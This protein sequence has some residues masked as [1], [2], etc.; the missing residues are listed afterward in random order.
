MTNYSNYPVFSVTDFSNSI[1]KIV[2]EN[3]QFVRIRGEISRPAFPASGHIYFSLKDENGSISAIIWKYNSFNLNLTLEEGLEVICSGKITTFSTQSKYQILVENI[4]LAG[5]GALLKLLELRKK[6]LA[7]EGI[8]DSKYKKKIPFLPKI[9]GVVTSLSGAVIKDI[10]NRLEDRFPSHVFIWPVSVQGKNASFEIS[11]A[12]KGFNSKTFFK[13]L[14]KP[15][16]IIVARGGGSIEDLWCFNEELIIRAVFESEIPVISAIGHETDTTLIDLVADLRV[17]TPSAAA[18]KAVPVLNDLKYKLRDL[19]FRL[20]KNIS[21]KISQFDN[22]LEAS[23]LLYNQL[24]RLI[25]MKRQR[26]DLLL[27]DYNYT[28]ANLISYKSNQISALAKKMNSPEK[29]LLIIENTFHLL[30]KQIKS[31]LKLVFLKNEEKIS[32]L[33]RL[34]ESNSFE[35]ILERGFTITYDTNLRIIKKKSGVKPGQAIKILFQD[36]S[37]KA[38]LK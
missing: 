38:I 21:N 4:E 8:F 35:K 11:N 22:I 18:E 28:F 7:L 17:P 31:S 27:K 14:K 5:E 24:E 23:N 13:T 16:V 29:K 37:N 36:G 9:I 20:E 1:K 2:E 34:L 33:S 15:D 32:S 6:N 19:S 12:I 3:F 25:V 30:N 10:L 26:L